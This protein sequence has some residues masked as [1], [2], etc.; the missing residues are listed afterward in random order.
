MTAIITDIQELAVMMEE[1]DSRVHRGQRRSRDLCF[2]PEG[3]CLPD[4][5]V[6]PFWRR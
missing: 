3:G 1:F 4:G 2:L 6:T 5:P